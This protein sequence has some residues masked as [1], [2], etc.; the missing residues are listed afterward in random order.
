MADTHASGACA[1]GCEGSN[2]F[3]HT[4]EPQFV[5]MTSIWGFTIVQHLIDCTSNSIK[6]NSLKFK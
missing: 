1:F 6:T 2:P 3:L 5:F 4:I